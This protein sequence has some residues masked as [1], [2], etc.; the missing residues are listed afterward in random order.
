MASTSVEYDSSPLNA[1]STA[2]SKPWSR[3]GSHAEGTAST[4]S[5]TAP[6]TVWEELSDLRNRLN[7]LELTGQSLGSGSRNGIRERPP[8]ATTTTTMSSSPKHDRLRNGSNEASTVKEIATKSTHPLL[9][10][11]LERSKDVISPKVFEALEATASDALALAAMTN[12][13]DLDGEVDGSFHPG[14]TTEATNRPLRRKADGLCRSLTELCI[15]LS[16]AKETDSIKLRPESRDTA[17]PTKANGIAAEDDRPVRAV[18]LEPE[19][20]RA[21]SRVM[22][23]FEARRSSMQAHNASTTERSGSYLLEP[24]TTPTQQPLPTPP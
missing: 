23:R 3:R 18:S 14:G 15:A 11:A 8:T 17:R 19:Q 9:H 12:E 13:G 5:T 2:G 7:R 4:V 21:S 10:A 22:S 16:D 6:S 1:Y 20:T 24:T